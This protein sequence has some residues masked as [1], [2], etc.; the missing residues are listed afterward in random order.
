MVDLERLCGYGEMAGAVTGRSIMSGLLVVIARAARTMV[1]AVPN[2]VITCS[3]GTLYPQVILR[4]DFLAHAER[5]H[6]EN[7]DNEK[8][9]RKF[10]HTTM[11]HHDVLA[12]PKIRHDDS[13]LTAV[14]SMLNIN[15]SILTAE[16]ENVRPA[17]LTPYAA[18]ASA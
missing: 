7:H 6:R 12:K 11:Q 1:R 2:G 17:K 8:Q 15:A 18:A 16:D 10:L 5:R 13:P 3:L 4:V 9:R 14:M